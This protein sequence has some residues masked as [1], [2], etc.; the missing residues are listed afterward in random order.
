MPTQSFE[1]GALVYSDVFSKR[2][3]YDISNNLLTAQFDGTGSIS[4]YAVVNKWDFIECY[5]NQMSVNGLPFDYYAEKRVEM[6]G[7]IQTV[8]AAF[9]GAD[10]TVRQF[11]DSST[12][13][14][15]TEFEVFAGDGDVVFENTVNFG[16]NITSWMKNFFSARF[17]AGNLSRLI[18]G[19]L[20]SEIKGHKKTEKSDDLLIIR[21]TVIENFYF[22]F[23]VTG[24]AEALESNHLYINQF[25]SAITV[26]KGETKK[27]R[28]VLSAGTRKDF[29]Y[30]DVAECI[31]D[32]DKYYAAAVKY[33]DDMP[34]P[35]SCKTD[36]E[37][38]YFR[39]LYNTAVSMYK[40]VGAFRGFIAG[41][42]YQSPA[43]TYYRDGYWTAISV[44]KNRPELVRNEVLT[45]AA[46]IDK[47]GK[48]PSA[49]KFNFKN[50]WGNHYD[51]PSF[52]AIL[53]YDYVR[54]TGDKSI[55]Q[56]KAG[57]Q[58]VLSAAVKV[59]EKLSEY[60]DDTG[61]L[62][63]RGPY[64]RRDW[65][66]NVFREG[67]VTYDEALYARALYALSRLTREYDEASSKAYFLRYEK[68]KAAINDILWDPE[69]GYYVNYKNESYTEKNLSVD[70]VVTVLYSI[71]P[72]D[73]AA[74]VLKNMERYL[75]S[76]NNTEQ[77]AGDFGVLSVYPFYKPNRSVVLKSSLPYYYHNGGD[78]PYLSA[79][80]AYAKMMYGMEYKYP[81]TRWFEYNL[82]KL[83]F[84]PV[85]F[86]APPHPDGSLLQG[87]SALGQLCYSYPDGDFFADRD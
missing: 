17:T 63:K 41:I 29:S 43:R 28:I 14:L 51:S 73:R 55:L 25:A 83:N 77:K 47:D 24:N 27:L 34:V 67:Y 44:L 70:T 19:T 35:E 45:L 56:E 21:N 59:I 9:N 87:W 78:W 68:V 75:E 84:T 16:L 30:T 52:F 2:C 4:K 3:F 31:K 48:C 58:T 81:L 40:E 74:S 7:R 50:W 49:V 79:A 15:F 8:K 82:G 65:C 20:G 32:F 5:Y 1:N 62:Y 23:A 61:L 11:A 72:R 66:D 80:Y 60:S 69:L 33:I 76:K 57:G 46:G 86:F 36:F 54:M 12:N 22:D 71:A 10:I 53:L 6:C 38:A 42:V 18:F 13:A 26:P 39:S 85:E 64:N 37:K